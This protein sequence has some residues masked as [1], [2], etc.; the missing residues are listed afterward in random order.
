MQKVGA[1][2]LGNWPKFKK[3]D[4]KEKYFTQFAGQK[5]QKDRRAGICRQG[6]QNLVNE[7]AL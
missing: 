6:D 3:Y 5:K 2:R 4:E 7:G 1:G